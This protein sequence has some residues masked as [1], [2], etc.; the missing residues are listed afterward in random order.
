MKIENN[1]ITFDRQLLDTALSITAVLADDRLD[2][3]SR[4]ERICIILDVNF[5]RPTGVLQNAD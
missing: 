2:D 4:L 3:V 1:Q 5:R